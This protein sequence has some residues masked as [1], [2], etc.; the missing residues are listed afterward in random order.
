MLGFRDDSN[1]VCGKHCGTVA[2]RNVVMNTW[3]QETG[4]A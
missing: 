1:E 3:R 4:W 2:V